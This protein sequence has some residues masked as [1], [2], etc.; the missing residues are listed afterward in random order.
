MTFSGQTKPLILSS[1]LDDAQKKAIQRSVATGEI[2]RI[3]PGIFSTLPSSDWPDLLL[4]EKLR[5]ISHLYPNSV[6]SHRSAFDALKGNS[7]YLT[8]PGRRKEIELHGLNIT[9]FPGP[10][11]TAGDQRMGSG[12][13]YFSSQARMFLDNLSRND[14]GRNAPREAVEDR[15]LQICQI[16]GEEK[17]LALRAEAE[18][19]APKLDRTKQALEL[20]KIVGAIL[21]TNSSKNLSSMSVAAASSGCDALRLE[22]FDALICELKKTPLASLRDPVET[23]RS[24]KHFAFIESYFSNFIEGTEFEIE[25]A[26]EI[27]LDGKIVESR[28]KDS[29]DIIG[30]FDQ[31]T[32]PGWRLQTLSNSSGCLTQLTERH[33]A[34]MA[35]RPE[36]RPGELK[37][38]QNRAGNTSFVHP[39]LVRGTLVAG[40]KRLNEVEPG[41]AR[42]LY[43]MFLVAEVHP[44]D[45]GNGRI[46]RL[47]MNAELSQNKECRII[48]PTLYREQYL[49]CLRVLTREGNPKP[50]IKAMTYIQEWT[51]DFDFDDLDETLDSMSKCNAFEKSLIEF[52][53][54]KNYKSESIGTQD[55]PRFS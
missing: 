10:G 42:A 48:I 29:H 37:L 50:F 47:I 27:I 8:M 31:I 25:E 7:L 11:Q 23:S 18:L 33:A 41:L 6:V 55:R 43:A 51:S 54:E 45:D 20:G 21:G 13:V 19:L 15:L 12:N 40:A 30:V 38:L 49:D 52:R 36:T 28:P 2:H 3:W 53:L 35:A 5:L 26:R 22:R 9:A 24:M 34:M 46:A 14:A 16:Q 1:E 39:R 4:R 17:L 44:F 32:S